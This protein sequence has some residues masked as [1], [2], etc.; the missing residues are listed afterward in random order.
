MRINWSVPCVSLRDRLDDKKETCQ[1]SQSSSVRILG[2]V[3]YP[4]VPGDKSEWMLVTHL[5]DSIPIA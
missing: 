4:L 5:L 3:G 2:Y 1:Q